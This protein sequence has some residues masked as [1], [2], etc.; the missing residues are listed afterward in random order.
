V[1]SDVVE[2]ACLE[3]RKRGHQVVEQSLADGS[4]EVTIQVGGVA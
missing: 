3:G 1:Y 4:I 2:K